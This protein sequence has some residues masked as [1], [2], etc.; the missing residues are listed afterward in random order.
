[1]FQQSLFTFPQSQT[2]L[3]SLF[4]FPAFALVLQACNLLPSV[5]S[6]AI[7]KAFSSCYFFRKKQTLLII[8]IKIILLYFDVLSYLLFF[9]TTSLSTHFGLIISYR[10]S[11]LID[12]RCLENRDHSLLNTQLY[13][14]QLGNSPAQFSVNIHLMSKRSQLLIKHIQVKR[15]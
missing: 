2:F 11:S 10:L 13:S 5:H 14:Q 4:S 6:L 7:F 8:Q 9:P 1:M 3:Q 15:I 12:F